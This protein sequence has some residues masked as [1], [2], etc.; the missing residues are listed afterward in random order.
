MPHIPGYVTPPQRPS[1]SRAEDLI[2]EIRDMLTGISA[3][4]G[5]GATEAT[6]QAVLVALGSLNVEA[7]Q[8]NVLAALQTANTT[9]N[10]LLAKDTCCETTNDLLTQIIGQIDTIQNI[11]LTDIIQQIGSVKDNT[12]ALRGIVPM[13]NTS[14]WWALIDNVVAGTNVKDLTIECANGFVYN[15]GFPVNW[16]AATAMGRDAI[17]SD[18][19][20]FLG[21]K[22]HI[23]NTYDPSQNWWSMS[24]EDLPMFYWDPN[25]SQWSEVTA[26]RIKF[27]SGQVFDFKRY[28][29]I[30]TQ[31]GF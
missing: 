29:Y 17:L 3:G 15:W 24:L 25:I 28:N 23:K 13:F 14:S 8:Q 18:L 5:S 9:L 20:S 22:V 31:N 26:V 21:R 2:E 11:Y 4:S 19:G 7:T 16:D 1:N 10:G 6:L 12:F 27:G 30:Q